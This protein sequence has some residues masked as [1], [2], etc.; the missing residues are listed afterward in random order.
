MEIEAIHILG[1]RMSSGDKKK[2]GKESAA[3][4]P[5]SSVK[6]EDEVKEITH[7]LT[8]RLRVAWSRW[9]PWHLRGCL[10][11]LSR[12]LGRSCTRH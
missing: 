1:H 11:A 4:F 2:R 12:G 10:V 3:S 5:G 8:T 7:M 9:E 6:P